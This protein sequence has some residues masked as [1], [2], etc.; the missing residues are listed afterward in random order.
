MAAKTY[1]TSEAAKQ[2]GVSRQTLQEWISTGKIVAPKLVAVPGASLR[3][4][5]AT[6]IERARKF[7]GTSKPGPEKKK[8][9]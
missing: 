1:S 3:I 9:K 4:W 8:K 5:T 7:K 2:I 6:D